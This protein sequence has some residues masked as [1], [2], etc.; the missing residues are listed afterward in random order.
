VP[1]CTFLF[2]FSLTLV[3]LILKPAAHINTPATNTH[4]VHSLYEHSL[5]FVQLAAR[6]TLV[7]TVIDSG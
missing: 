6:E 3:T 1:E 4:S 2:Y 5:A 7:A